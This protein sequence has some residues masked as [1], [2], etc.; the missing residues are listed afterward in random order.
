[1]KDGVRIVNCARGELVDNEAIMSAA[2][3]GK[4][5]A[6]VTDFPNAAIVGKAGMICIPHLGASTEE[7]EDNC[8]VMAAREMVDYIENGNIVN[9]VNFPAVKAEKTAARTLVLSYG[10]AQAAVTKLVLKENAAITANV[11]K[12]FGAMLIDTDAPL[13]SELVSAI[14]KIDGV[15]KVRTID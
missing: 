7:A 15:I 1:M 13:S 6:Y 5:T 2:A 11:K 9:S 3:S 8:A 10:D 4:V 14:K 12:N